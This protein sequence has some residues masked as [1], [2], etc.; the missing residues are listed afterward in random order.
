M[1]ALQLERLQLIDAQTAQ[2]NRMIVQAMKPQQETVLR[3]VEVPGLGLDSARQI[4]AEVGAQA[5]TFGSAAELTSWVG[6]CPGKDESAE[7]NRSSRS[8]KG[9]KYL[10]RMLNQAARKLGYDVAIT[11][12][13]FATPN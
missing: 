5:G 13:N 10:R 8:A 12:T 11:P 4:I 3:L 9:N 6:T 2:L 1:L 7:Q